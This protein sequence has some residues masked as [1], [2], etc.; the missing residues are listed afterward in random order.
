MAPGHREQRGAGVGA[1]SGAYADDAAGVLVRG[2]VGVRQQRAH[3][4]GLERLDG[5]RAELVR[6]EAEVHQ[7][8]RAAGRRRRVDEV[9]HL[10]G[11][12]GDGDVGL[13]V[14]AVD[15]AGVD[16]DA[17]RDVDGHHGHA[18]EALEGRDRTRREARASADPDD[19]VDDQVRGRVEVAGSLVAR[20]PA[21]RN[22]RR[23]DSWAR[24]A[25][26]SAS[27]CAPRP[28]RRAPAQRASP[29]LSPGPTS[30]ST[31]RP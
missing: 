21:V 5:G 2:L 18:R 28:A 9:S 15:P 10:V 22:A 11:A 4:V 3:V 16:V 24:S 8:Q 30:S 20:P 14:R 26:R 23:P 17:R 27:T 6:V 29:P 31:R 25:S 7:V 13:H 1:R 19:A 12:E